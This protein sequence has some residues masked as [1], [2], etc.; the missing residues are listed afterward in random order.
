MNNVHGPSHI[1]EVS[2]G[3]W[4]S[5]ALLSAV[6]LEVFTRLGDKAMTGEDLG[7]VVDLHPRAIWD[8]FDALVAL[9][10]LD[11]DGDGPTALYHNTTDM[12]RL[13]ISMSSYTSEIKPANG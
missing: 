11:R 7:A 6:E 3:F 13:F 2:F 4:T 12:A 9:G 5:K 10:F 8:F 1:L